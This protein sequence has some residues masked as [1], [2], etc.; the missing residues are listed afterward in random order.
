MKKVFESLFKKTI[1][2]VVVGYNW[3][4]GTLDLVYGLWILVT[5]RVHKDFG[6]DF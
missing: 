6:F 1:R 3:K 5:V 4:I 2:V